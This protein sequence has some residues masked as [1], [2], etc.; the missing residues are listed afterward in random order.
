MGEVVGPW[1]EDRTIA[2]GD[3]EWRPS[4]SSLR[5]LEGPQMD[6]QDL[7]F[8]QGWS[9]AQRA[10]DEVTRDLLESAPPRHTPRAILLDAVDTEAGVA[11]V[12]ANGP[13][14]E[15]PWSEAGATTGP[16]RPG[17]RGGH[18]RQAAAGAPTR[19]V[20]RDPARHDQHR[21]VRRLHRVVALGAEGDLA[22][23]RLGPRADHQQVDRPPPLDDA[24]AERR[25]EALGR[26]PRG[27][28]ALV[29]DPDRV[30]ADRRV[31]GAAQPGRRRSPRGRRATVCG[32]RCRA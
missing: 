3:R 6:P 15:I 16:P 20:E 4:E 17:D 12:L 10:S 14:R 24:G 31:F 26:L 8:G 19:E 5:I 13:G 32:R 1:L 18:P 30:D 2:M 11:D 25:G 27:R 9:N 22:L 29:D 7:A 23:G 28:V 21:V